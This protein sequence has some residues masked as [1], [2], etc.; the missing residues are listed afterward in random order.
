M[1]YIVSSSD[2]VY[3]LCKDVGFYYEPEISVVGI[4]Y[5]SSDIVLYT[6]KHKLQHGYY[7]TLRRKL[8]FS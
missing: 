7:F 8:R 3:V 2:Y 4:F 6:N 5:Y 1:K